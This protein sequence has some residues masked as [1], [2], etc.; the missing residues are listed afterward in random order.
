MDAYVVQGILPASGLILDVQG[1]GLEPNTEYENSL[2]GRR[3]RILFYTN[4]DE[5]QYARSIS[6][7]E[8]LCLYGIITQ[9]GE[10]NPA[11][12]FSMYS[13]LDA[14][15]PH[16]LLYEFCRIIMDTS[17]SRSHILNAFIYSCEI[18]MSISQCLHIEHHIACNTLDWENY[19][20]DDNDTFRII[21][22][23]RKHKAYYC[24]P[25]VLKDIS[26][27]YHIFLKRGQLQMLNNHS[28]F[29]KPV[30][31]NSNYLALIVVP[32]SLRKW[33]FDHYHSGLAGGYMNKYKTL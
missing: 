3:C 18:K 15:L 11:L 10:I 12:L 6:T 4:D 29:Y 2:F 19:Y 5:V 30:R 24:L 9:H 1:P 7:L 28:I 27:K 14:L 23:L 22:H 13:T 33:F 25:T 8:L 20:K 32:Q 16:S 21:Y 17:T 31:M 26:G